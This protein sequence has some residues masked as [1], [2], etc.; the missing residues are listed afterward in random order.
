M[1]G[2]TVINPK[3]WKQVTLKEV[4]VGKLSYGSGASAVEYDGNYRYVRIT[5]ITTTG[6]LNSD[7]KSP[8][9]FD[10]KYLLNDGDIL[11]ARSGATV[12]KTFQYKQSYGK[13]L[14]AGYLIRLIPNREL[15]IPEYVFNYTKTSY[16]TKFIES[17][18]KVVAQPN[19]N[20]QQYGD[21]VICIP[22]LEL[23]NEFAQ[24]VQQVDKLKFEMEQVFKRLKDN[25]CFLESI[26]R[27]TILTV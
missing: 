12:G 6:N 7:I 21:L 4:S 15:V 22:P 10:E 23:Q 9:E 13:C 18:M 2:D 16:Y 25:F 11:F 1:F 17:N 8:S 20:A 27:E 14:Y 24:F 3:G 19:I 5:D 26:S